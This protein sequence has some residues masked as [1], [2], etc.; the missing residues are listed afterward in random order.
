[1]VK[2]ADVPFFHNRELTGMQKNQEPHSLESGPW[3]LYDNQLYIVQR[4]SVFLNV[5]W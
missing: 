3:L 5:D 1:M 4:N 2:T